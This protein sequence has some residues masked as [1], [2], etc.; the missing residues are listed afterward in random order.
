M[1]KHLRI[2]VTALSV[3][4]CVL[5]VGLWV[6]SYRWV[7]DVK[8]VESNDR[9]FVVSLHNGRVVFGGGVVALGPGI[10]LGAVQH[11]TAIEAKSVLGYLRPIGCVPCWLAATNLALFASAP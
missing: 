3:T 2:A 1:L 4:A 6:R 8:L 5:L 11:S 10:R 9:P 7:V